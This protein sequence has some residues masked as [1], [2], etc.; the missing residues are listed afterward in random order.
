[1]AGTGATMI[2]RDEAIQATNLIFE[3]WCQQKACKSCP[4][5]G[6]R[7]F[8]PEQGYITCG[9]YEEPC[10]WNRVWNGDEKKMTNLEVLRQELKEFIDKASEADLMKV[11]LDSGREICDCCAYNYMLCG[12]ECIHGFIAWGQ[13]EYKEPEDETA[14]YVCG[15]DCEDKLIKLLEGLQV[16]RGATVESLLKDGFTN[17]S[18]PI[19]HK[20]WRIKLKDKYPVSFVMNIAKKTLKIS[21]VIV[22]DECFG[23]P[24]PCGKE[25]YMQ[26]EQIV[27]E[28]VNKK[29]LERCKD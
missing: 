22:F 3:F 2:T 13:Q 6:E 21:E 1:M 20:S 12:Q 15:G 5:C 8:V 29:I 24:H 17:Y 16:H 9:I 27:N 23:Q 18:E 11:V 14:L 26:I 10:A 4:F 25:E 19:L 28:L 7:I